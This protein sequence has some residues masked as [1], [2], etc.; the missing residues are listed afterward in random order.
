V[1]NFSS[2][3]QFVN[4]ALA[5]YHLAAGSPCIDAASNPAVP[6][7]VTEDLD[8]HRRFVDDPGTLDTG[9]GRA[10]IVDMGAYEFQL[11]F[12]PAD[13]NED[14]DVDGFDLAMLLGAWTGAASYAPCPP[15]APADL[16]VDCKVNG[17]D[18]AI[19]L[20]EWG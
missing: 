8:G 14:G 5:D 17:L 20:G 4:P 6:H 10:P 2:D 15:H 12:G 3:P 1:G 19:L 18:L 16:N 13:L 11:P 7:G 9:L